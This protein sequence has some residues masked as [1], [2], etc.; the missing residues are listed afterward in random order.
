VHD[1]L[2]VLLVTLFVAK[3]L[4]LLLWAGLD[5]FLWFG[6]LPFIL[7]CWAFIALALITLFQQDDHP[8]FLD[9]ITHVEINTSPFQMALRNV[10]AMLPHVVYFHVPPF[11]SLL[12]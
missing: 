10:Q 7:G 9:A 12:V 3:P 8:I 1:L 5:S 2:V 6:L 4:F 11:E